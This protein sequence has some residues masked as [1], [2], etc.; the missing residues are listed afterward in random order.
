LTIGAGGI[1]SFD[2]SLA[3]A[4]PISISSPSPEAQAVPEPGTQILLAV[5]AVLGLSAR[6]IGKATKSPN[7]KG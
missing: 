4:A 3:V 2:P 5:G 7:V 1:F 6:W